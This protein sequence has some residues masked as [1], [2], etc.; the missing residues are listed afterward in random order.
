MS[1]FEWMAR[2]V[3]RVL[4]WAR[5]DGGQARAR[6]NAWSA[7]VAD[8]RRRTQRIEV[9]RSVRGALLATQDPRPVAEALSV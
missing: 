7:M 3:Q 2:Q 5:P 9:D 6:R 4:L 8:N 1:E